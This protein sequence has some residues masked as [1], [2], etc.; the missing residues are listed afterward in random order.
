MSNSVKLRRSNVPNR[1]PNTTQLPIG[2]MAINT[3]DKKSYFSTGADIIELLGA[4]VNTL[5]T[6]QFTFNPTIA[7]AAFVLG[8]NAQGQ[9]ITGLNADLLDGQDATNFATASGLATHISDTALHLTSAQNTWLDSITASAVEINYL[10]G[11]TSSVQTQL[12][13]K[14]ASLGFTPENTANKGAANG[15]CPLDATSKISATYL[16]SYVDDVLEYANLAAFPGTGETGKMYLDLATNKVYRWSGT[17]YVEISASPGS[18]DAVPEGSTNLYF[19]PA[20]A[21][22]AITGGASSIVTSNLTLSRALVSDGS[23]K[24]AVAATTS[25]ELGYVSG[26]TSAIQTQLDGKQPLD[27]DLTAFAALAANGIVARTGT[28]AVAARSIQG[29]TNQITLTNGDGV[30][31]NPIVTLANDLVLP[32]TG[33]FTWPAGTTAQRPVSPSNGDSRFNTDLG[34][35]EQ[36]YAGTWYPIPRTATLGA[37]Q[38]RRTTTY[39]TTLTFTDLTFDVVDVASNTAICNRDG[40]NTQRFVAYEA[41]FYEFHFVLTAIAT[42]TA[43]VL[44]A[45]MVVNGTTVLPATMTERPAS[46]TARDEISMTQFV[47]LAANDYVTLQLSHTSNSL[48]IQIGTVGT[49]KKLEGSVGQAGAPGGTNNYQFSAAA[50]DNPNN[51]GWASN[52]LAPIVTDSVTTSLSVRAFDDTLL[53]GVGFLLNIPATASSI[54]FKFTYRAASAPAS[55]VNAIFQLYTKEI[56]IG[57]AVGAWSAATTL[58]SIPLT[59]DTNYHTSLQSLTLASLGL[60]AGDTVQFQLVRNGASASDTLVGD[61]YLLNA[62]VTFS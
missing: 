41:G 17:V 58:S 47:Q 46:T 27:S 21:Q 53:E 11:V 42:N 16:P 34:V 5:V 9:L 10:S 60:V 59:V 31:G 8:A 54:S 43:G 7:Q 29:T 20:R 33:K 28:G 62:L 2:E 22:A 50:F 39:A 37:V 48:T 32:G 18:T 40:T 12:N 24:V 3:A 52:A 1:V 13:G 4:S 38:A 14:Q 44:N 15:Y 55:A 49:M 61:F 57:A 30:S 26:V 56:N 19:T 23:G 25:T 51:A 35:Y 45:R 6:A 36:Y